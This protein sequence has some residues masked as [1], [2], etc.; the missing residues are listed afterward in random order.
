MANRGVL[1]NK[2]RYECRQPCISAV[3]FALLTF[4]AGQN[5]LLANPLGVTLPT[6]T[7]PTVTLPTGITV[8]ST[9]DP[10]VILDMLSSNAQVYLVNTNGVI[11]GA[12]STVDVAGLVATSLNLSDSDFL[13]GRDD[14][15]NPL[16]GQ[17]MRVCQ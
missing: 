14:R 11:F 12:G 17:P 7:L 5:V 1:H 2:T 3:C 4:F 16:S 10:S 8:V 15:A 6:V 13:S 9:N